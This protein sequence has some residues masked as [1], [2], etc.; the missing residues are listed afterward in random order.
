MDPRQY[1]PGTKRLLTQSGKIRNETG[2]IEVEKVSGH[3]ESPADRTCSAP[4]KDVHFREE[5]RDLNL[6]SF[7]AIR[8]VHGVGVN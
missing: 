2:C 6:R 7:R 5:E 3:H 1:L 4:G 8:S